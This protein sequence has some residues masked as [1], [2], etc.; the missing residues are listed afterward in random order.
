MK[1][2]GTEYKRITEYLNTFFE[3]DE[4]YDLT[5]V[6]RFIAKATEIIEISS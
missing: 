3:D 5:V 4:S 6:V 2:T 1:R